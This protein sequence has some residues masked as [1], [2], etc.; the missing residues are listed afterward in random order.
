MT[1]S[2]AFIHAHCCRPALLAFVVACAATAGCGSDDPGDLQYD[3][4]IAVLGTTVA[5]GALQ[6][7]VSYDGASGGWVG[8]QGDV[9]CEALVDALMAA[10]YVGEG[11]V[12]IGLVSIEGIPAPGPVVRCGF[13]GPLE[14]STSSFVVQVV[15]AS[16]T[17]SAPVEPMPAMRVSS[18]VTR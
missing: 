4:T 12:K 16:D 17:S 6:F 10:N 8:H 18:V 9:E 11:T 1:S 15:D 2:F 3:V 14:I 13:R 7:D 5:L